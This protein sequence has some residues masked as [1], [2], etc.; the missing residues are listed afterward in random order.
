MIR[1]TRIS[2]GAAI[3][4]RPDAIV[5]IAERTTDQGS[6]LFTTA[7]SMAVLEPPEK[8]MEMME[9]SDA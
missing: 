1:L 5:Q 4:V 9:E 2:D 6:I 7:G 8:V 3:W